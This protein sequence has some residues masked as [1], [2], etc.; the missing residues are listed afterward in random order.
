MGKSGLDSGA[1]V[2]AYQTVD[3]DD[4]PPEITVSQFFERLAPLPPLDAKPLLQRIGIHL[5]LDLVDE[6]LFLPVRGS[7]VV[8]KAIDE[9]SAIRAFK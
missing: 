3:V 2:A 9:D 8:K 1:D 4:R 5:P 7:Q 6:L